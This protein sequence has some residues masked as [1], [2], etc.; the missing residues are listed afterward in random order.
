MGWEGLDNGALLAAAATEF[1]VFLSVDKKIQYE[2]DLN[3]LPIPTILL[4]AFSNALPGLA[5]FAPQLQS[6]LQS[7]LDPALYIIK[8][9][10]G[11]SRLGNSINPRNA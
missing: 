6:L 1:D 4:D 8:R 7:K 3:R 10:G 11:V 2:H 9:D 5:G